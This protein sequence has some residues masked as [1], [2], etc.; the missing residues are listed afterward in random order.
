M[1]GK[2][3]DESWRGWLKENIERG[4][5]A[6]DLYDRL[7]KRGFSQESIRDAMG[8]YYPE[9]AGEQGNDKSDIVDYESFAS[10]RITR[11]DNGLNVMQFVSDK[12]Q[13]FVLDDFLND[14]ECDRIVKVIH[15]HLRP[16]TV[17]RENEDKAYRTSTTSDLALL[18]APVEK[19][20]VRE[21]DKKIAQTLG[22]SLPYSEGIQAQR[23]DVG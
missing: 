1:S 7:T 3:L 11:P 5:G 12:L 2:E 17:T 22:I 8:D 20:I 6:Y 18:K 4:C 15:K 21:M 19:K 10:P 16:S 23:Y 14:K 9:A 13:I